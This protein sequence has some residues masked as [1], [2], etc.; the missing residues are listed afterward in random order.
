MYGNMKP[1]D[2]LQPFVPQPTFW[3]VCYVVLTFG[4]SPA[5]LFR[6]A[7]S[8]LALGRATFPPG[9]GI[10][11][12]MKKSPEPFGSRDESLIRGTT[13]LISLGEIPSGSTKPYP[14]NGGNRVP[15]LRPCPFTGPTQEPDLRAQS[16]GSHR[17]PA[18]WSM[19]TGRIF[20][21]M[22]FRCIQLTLKHKQTGLSTS[23]E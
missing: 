20:P 3:E 9:E 12:G 23:L 18:L 16:T 10:G 2:L 8:S 22:S 1:E 4:L 5:F 13:L 6:P 11:A 14:G 15:L 21:S 17:P 7:F 19:E